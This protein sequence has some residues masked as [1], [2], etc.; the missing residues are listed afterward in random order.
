MDCPKG[1]TRDQSARCL[2]RGGIVRH[3][4]D[5]ALWSTGYCGDIPETDAPENMDEV[6]TFSECSVNMLHDARKQCA[7]FLWTARSLLR[8]FV[9]A[10][11]LEET[12]SRA[13]HDLWLTAQGHG[14]G[15]WDGDWRLRPLDTLG[16]P[17]DHGDALTTLAKDHGYRGDLYHVGDYSAGTVHME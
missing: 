11:G 9:R 2:G 8:P 13:G 5:T 12:L 14:A 16:D 17:V 15:F 1:F 10:W 4:I 7:A 6:A 3:Y